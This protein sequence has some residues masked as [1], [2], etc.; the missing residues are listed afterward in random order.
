MSVEIVAADVDG[1][2]SATWKHATVAPQRV[3][4]GLYYAEVVGVCFWDGWVLRNFGYLQV[5]ELKQIGYRHRLC[6]Y[7]TAWRFEYINRCIR[8]MF[9]CLKPIERF[10]ARFRI[11]FADIRVPATDLFRKSS[12]DISSMIPNLP[13]T[14]VGGCE[15]Q[16]GTTAESFL[17]FSTWRRYP[18]VSSV[19]SRLATLVTLMKL[20]AQWNSTREIVSWRR[21]SFLVGS[22]LKLI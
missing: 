14:S 13:I 6:L 15:Q 11:V 5:P 8:F 9:S 4:P 18:W 19:T 12:A 3:F 17:L 1:C 2:D 20:R 7:M 21:S 22:G 10:V 16:R